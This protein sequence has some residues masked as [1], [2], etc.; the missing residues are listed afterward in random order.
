[1]QVNNNRPS[2]RRFNNTFPSI[3]KIGK[4]MLGSCRT[5]PATCS[6]PFQQGALCSQLRQ[7]FTDLIAELGFEVPMFRCS[8]VSCV[9]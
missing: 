5:G 4:I 8:T 2:F 9:T 6:L 1:M 3:A 7:Y